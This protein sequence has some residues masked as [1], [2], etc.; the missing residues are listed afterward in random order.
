MLLLLSLPLPGHGMEKR[1]SSEFVFAVRSFVIVVVV[2][3]CCC[4]RCVFLNGYVVMCTY[5][6]Y[7]CV[8]EGCFGN[9]RCYFTFFFSG[10]D[11]DDVVIWPCIKCSFVASYC[12]CCCCCHLLRFWGPFVRR[13]GRSRKSQL[14]AK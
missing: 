14:H 6:L 2:R 13:L 11:D 9:Q 10:N 4:C 3:R 7:V 5:Y 12:C 8:C 1:V